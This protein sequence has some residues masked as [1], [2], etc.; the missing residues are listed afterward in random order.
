MARYK[1]KN[2]I[3]GVKGYYKSKG[4]WMAHI[5]KDYKSIGLGTFET[6]EEAIE[7][8]RKAVLKY[9]G[10]DFVTTE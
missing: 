8:R 10:E 2:D 3:T 1:P 9:F 6:K 7:A 5:C 4:K